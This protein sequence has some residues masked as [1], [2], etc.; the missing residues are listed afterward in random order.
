MD[1]HHDL[2][3]IET[4]FRGAC[5]TLA[6]NRGAI[7]DRLAAAYDDFLYPGFQPRPEIPQELADRIEALDQ[8]M[9]R[10]PRLE[11]DTSLVRS[12]VDLMTEDQRYEYAR[13]LWEIWREIVSEIDFQ[14]SLNQ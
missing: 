9:R 5:D 8:R 11:S 12:T 6:T 14:R 4:K 2:K 3:Y 1:G 13:E 10:G 7:A